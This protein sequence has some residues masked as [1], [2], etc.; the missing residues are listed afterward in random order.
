MCHLVTRA[1]GGEFDVKVNQNTDLPP[2]RVSYNGRVLNPGERITVAPNTTQDLVVI[3]DTHGLAQE[4]THFFNI[5]VN[6]AT[7]LFSPYE[8]PSP[9]SG[10]VFQIVI[11]RTTW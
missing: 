11:A 9:N 4:S 10:A 1:G 3:I 5:A 7:Y 2:V 6:P 8:V